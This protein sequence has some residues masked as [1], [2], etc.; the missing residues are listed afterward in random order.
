[1]S[2]RSGGLLPLALCLC[3]CLSGCAAMLERS[4]SFSELYVNR[5]WDTGAGDTLRAGTYQDLVNS[6]LMLVEQRAEEGV[7]RYS[8]R[9]RSY[10]EVYSAVAEVRQKTAL[11]SYLLRSMLFRYDAGEDDCTITVQITYREDAEDVGSLMLLSDSQSLVDLLRLHLR[12][13]HQRLTAQF[14][15]ETER[16]EDVLA[17]VQGL[18]TEMCLEEQAKEEEPPPEDVT[19]PPEGAD[20]LLETEPDVEADPPEEPPEEPPPDPEPP[21]AGEEEPQTEEIPPA[22]GEEPAAPAAGELEIPPCPWE[23]RFYPDTEY[24]GIVEIWL[25]EAGSL[26]NAPAEDY[27]EG[28]ADS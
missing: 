3:L 9:T 4:Y 18:W 24:A 2:R 13:E 17:A 20:P 10:N 27:N 7:V 11:G 21:A 19:A 5:Y 23:V 1:M 6:L 14:V 25:H 8:A 16:R 22:E 26:D 12:E 15:Y 28:Q